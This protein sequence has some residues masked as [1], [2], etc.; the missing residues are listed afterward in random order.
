MT[1]ERILVVEDDLWQANF[2]RQTLGVEGFDVTVLESGEAFFQTLESEH[3]DAV[4]LDLTLPDED[5]I[6]LARKL[7]ARSA[8]PII[9]VTSREELDDKLASFDVGAD[10]Y[11]TKPIEPKELA[12]R[13][14]VVIRRADSA[15]NNAEVSNVLG[16]HR[17]DLERREVLSAD[18]ETIQLTPAEFSLIA[19]LYHSNNKAVTRDE[20][21]DAVSDGDGPLSFRAVDILVSRVRKKLGKDLIETVTGTGYRLAAHAREA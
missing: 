16:P 8:L 12:A 10:D 5:G 20:I 3:F 1:A 13:L 18:G 19:A 2:I 21:V 4:V 15:K 17:I 11:M 9:V 14:R 6:V 7:R